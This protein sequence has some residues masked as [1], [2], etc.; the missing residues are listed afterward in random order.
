[1]QVLPT[2]ALGCLLFL[3]SA[4]PAQQSE[5][6][7]LDG[8]DVA[9]YNLAGSLTVEP[10]TGPVAVD[11]TRGGADAARLRVEQGELEG[12][13]ALRVVYP[14]ESIVYPGIDR[15]SSTTLKVREDGTFGDGDSDERHRGRTVKV[16]GQ[17]QGVRAHADLKVRMPA[18]YRV[19]LYLAVGQVSITNVNGELL[20]DAHSAPVTAT[21]T[22]GTLDLD[23]GAGTVRVSG[24]QGSLHVDTGSGPVEV[25]GFSGADLS[26]DTGSGGVTGSR[27]EAGEI[28]IDTGSGDI[29]LTEVTAPAIALETGSGRVGAD[30]RGPVRELAVE[31]GSGDVSVRAPAS[32][33]ASVELETASGAIETDFPLQVTRHSRDHV[34]GRI[35]DG[36]GRVAIETGS[37]DVRLLKSPN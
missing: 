12:R 33:A 17:G 10:G 30:L 11:L 28:H 1:M 4:A 13:E 9:I 8:D 25:S 16:S 5:R 15:G 24:A 32:L 20:V 34:V 6:Y 26:I 35:G 31:T 22:R 37:G 27:L 14:A 2:L 3:P 7:T 29:E 19:S 23:V 21:G 18:G 36:A